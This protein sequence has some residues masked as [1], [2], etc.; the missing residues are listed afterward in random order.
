M[1]QFSANISTLFCEYPPLERIT[2]AR[3]AGFRAVEIQFPYDIPLEQWVAARRRAKIPVVLI[4]VPAGDLTTGGPGL[5]AVPGREQAFRDAVR[6]CARYAKALSV[7][8]VN[9]LAGAPPAGADRARCMERLVIN[10][11]HAAEVMSEI[12][13]RVVTEPVNLRVRPGFLLSTSA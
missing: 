11:R 12:G 13:V 2:A 7:R 9:V 4:N 10:L 1:P 6:E 3:R 5:A 8:V